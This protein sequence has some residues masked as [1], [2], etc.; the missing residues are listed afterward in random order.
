M[1]LSFGCTLMLI[2]WSGPCS[3]AGIL[4]AWLAGGA[5][6]IGLSLAIRALG[7]CVERPE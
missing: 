4:C 1:L 5:V 3:D 6:G 2:L 7:D